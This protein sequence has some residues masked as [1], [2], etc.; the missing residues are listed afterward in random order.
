MTSEIAGHGLLPN[1]KPWW[2]AVL[3]LM[4][5]F[6]YIQEDVKI[7]LNHYAQVGDHYLDFYSYQHLECDWEPECMYESRK[8]WW[9]RFAPMSRTSFYVTRDTF[10]VFH[11]MGPGELKRL[12][13]G[14]MVAIV[15][16]F[17]VLDAMFLRAAGV[18]ERWKLLML[19]YGASGLVTAVFWA[20]DGQAGQNEAGYNVAREVL[21]FLQSPLPSLMLVLLPWLRNRALEGRLSTK[22]ASLDEV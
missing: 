4:V 14:L 9:D 19:I 18:G 5:V 20:L 10:D 12:K 8:D 1:G 16:G 21:G 13:W 11:R 17:F 7:K 15:L 6:G 2:L 22:K 3:M